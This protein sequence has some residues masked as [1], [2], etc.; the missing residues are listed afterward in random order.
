MRVHTLGELSMS[1]PLDAARK[2]LEEQRSKLQSPPS[3]QQS[4]PAS[5]TQS[6]PSANSATPKDPD[7]LEIVTINFKAFRKQKLIE[8]LTP[9][10]ITYNDLSQLNRI[11]PKGRYIFIN[12]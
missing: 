3:S 5:S 1:K 12:R 8:S 10:G 9:F 7:G 2:Y 6:S 11:E 4:T